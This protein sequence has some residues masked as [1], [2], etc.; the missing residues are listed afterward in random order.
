[1]NELGV[2]RVKI[3]KIKPHKTNKNLLSQDWEDG[4]AVKKSTRAWI[5][6]HSKELHEYGGI[7]RES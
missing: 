1:M 6:G 5:P 7:S 4:S 3:L 2:L